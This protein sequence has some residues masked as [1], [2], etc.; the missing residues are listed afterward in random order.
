[1]EPAQLC[2][3]L[4]GMAVE[5]ERNPGDEHTESLLCSV[6]G[7]C[8]AGT[9]FAGTCSCFPEFLAL[10]CAAGGRRCEWLRMPAGP[11]LGVFGSRTGAVLQRLC[12]A[13]VPLCWQPAGQRGLR[14]SICVL[15]GAARNPAAGGAHC[16]LRP[17]K[18]SSV[19]AR[20][21][22]ACVAAPQAPMRTCV[23]SAAVMMP[24]AKPAAT[25]LRKWRPMVAR[26]S[27]VA[28]AQAAASQHSSQLRPASHTAAYAARKD[29][30][31]GAALRALG[32][33]GGSALSLGLC[34][35]AK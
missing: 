4:E 31:P 10:L 24:S 21:L 3:V 34:A 19:S 14:P 17:D 20:A 6:L 18:L 33:A 12:P 23:V 35:Q 29:T 27:A 2:K 25:S 30:L 8:F 5:S 26:D 15:R 32:V 7:T 9:C 22:A 13:P 1:M 28:S 16:V 11:R